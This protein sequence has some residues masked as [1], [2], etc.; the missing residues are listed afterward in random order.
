MGVAQFRSVIEI[1]EIATTVLVRGS[2]K[3]IW[4]GIYGIV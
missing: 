3:A 1:A 2:V 4:Y